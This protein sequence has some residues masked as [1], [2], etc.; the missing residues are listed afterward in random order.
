M[1]NMKMIIH[2]NLIENFPVITEYANLANIIFG[3]DI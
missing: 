1:E 2:Q 3:P